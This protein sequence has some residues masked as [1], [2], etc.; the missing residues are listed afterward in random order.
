M[1]F[2][3]QLFPP[4]LV[5]CTIVL[6]VL[7]VPAVLIAYI[8]HDPVWFVV[9]PFAIVL[10]TFI[11]AALTKRKRNVTPEQLADELERHL[12]GTEKEWDW[13]DVT[14]SAIAD[15]RLDQIRWDLPKF[16]S[17]VDEK[18][19]QELR[20]LIAALRRGEVPDVVPPRDLTYRP[21]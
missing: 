18:D 19:K 12:L 4:K 14:S 11:V 20:D 5:G 7:F 8:T 15:E 13:D 17:L 16:D 9:V 21:R 1:S 3:L 10:L 2:H 6:L